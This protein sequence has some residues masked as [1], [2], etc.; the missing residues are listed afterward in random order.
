MYHEI[1]RSDSPPCQKQKIDVNF[2]GGKLTSD[3]GVVLLQKVDQKLRDC[4]AEFLNL[5]WAILQSAQLPHNRHFSLPILHNL[6]K[7]V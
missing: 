7:L 1:A 6:C 5:N 2:N 4:S 3:A